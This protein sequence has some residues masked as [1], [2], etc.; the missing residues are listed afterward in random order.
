MVALKVV[1]CA[2]VIILIIIAIDVIVVLVLARTI[3]ILGALPLESRM[4]PSAVFT[5]CYRYDDEYDDDPHCHLIASSSEDSRSC[6]GLH[7]ILYYVAG[8]LL[9]YL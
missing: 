9:H 3:E 1:A 2:V 5:Q 8:W 7:F 4:L 6:P